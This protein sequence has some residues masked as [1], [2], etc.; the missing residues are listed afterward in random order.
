MTAKPTTMPAANN[1]L[2]ALLCVADNGQDAPLALTPVYGQPFLHHVVKILENIGISRFFVAVDAVP[3]AL[4]NYCDQARQKGVDIVCIRSPAE[5]APGLSDSARIVALTV[6]TVWHPEILQDALEQHRPLIATVEEHSEN[7]DFER[8]DLSN[9]WAGLLILERRNLATLVELPDGWDV[10][11]ALLRQAQQDRISHWQVTQTQLQKGR[12][13]K[14]AAD[15]DLAAQLGVVTATNDVSQNSLEAILFAPLCRKL[16]PYIWSFSWSRSAV[17]WLFPGLAALSA[18]LA[19]ANF[20]L[21]ALLMAIV[22]IFAGMVRRGALLLEYRLDER[23][24]IATIGWALSGAALATVLFH[25]ERSLVNAAFATVAVTLLSLF[26][27]SYWRKRDFWI[28]SPL[29]IALAALLGTSFGSVMWAIQAVVLAE[30]V[31]L[32]VSRLPQKAGEQVSIDR[33]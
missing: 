14:L 9:R 33:A 5:L 20:A 30:L 12:V 18:I 3:G 28:S 25:S 7:R 17:E 22:A 15:D 4:L 27:S 19:V 16:R 10:G 13:H 21:P 8:I 31:S 6:D 23:D 24:W 2:V 1:E 11:S 26:S 29:V 32:L